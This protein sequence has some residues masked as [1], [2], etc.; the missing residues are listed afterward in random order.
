MLNRPNTCSPRL[1]EE[2]PRAPGRRCPGSGWRRRRGRRRASPNV[3]QQAPPQLGNARR[4]SGSL[5][6]P[7]THL[8]RCRPAASIAAS[9]RCAERV[10]LD[11]ERLGRASPSPSI[12]TGPPARGPGRASRAP[13][14]ST[15]APASKRRRA[16]R[17]LTISYVDAE[18][19]VEAALRQA[20]LQRHLAAFEARRRVAARARA[21]GPCGRGRRSCRCPSRGRGRCACAAARDP[22]AGCRSIEIHRSAPPPRTRCATLRDHAAHRRVSLQRSPI[23]PMRARGRAR[24]ASARWRSVQPIALR[25]QRHLDRLASPSLPQRSSAERLAAQRRD[26][27]RASRSSASAAIVA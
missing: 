10:R 5:R 1:L 23:W 12:L 18:R 4:R 19:V 15:T 11:G 7:S 2:L 6:S 16:R 22:G 9:R 25:T 26:L 21:A 14:R 13:P 8:D 20:A 24:A 27:A 3:K 17:A